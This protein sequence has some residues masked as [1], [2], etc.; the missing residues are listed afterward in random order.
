MGSLKGGDKWMPLVQMQNLS[1]AEFIFVQTKSV[2]STAHLLCH[3]KENIDILYLCICCTSR[4]YRFSYSLIRRAA[5]RKSAKQQC[6]CSLFAGCSLA[7]FSACV[8]ALCPGTP[9]IPRRWSAALGGVQLL[10]CWRAP[11]H[12]LGLR[13]HA[14]CRTFPGCAP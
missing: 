11:W 8:C 14:L 4:S 2:C 3:R 9:T 13:S 12:V 6:V 7:A 5:C 10:N 1:G